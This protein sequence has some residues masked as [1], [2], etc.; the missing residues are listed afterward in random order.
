MG[1]E[2]S[3][4]III[5]RLE[6]VKS[7]KG[8]ASGSTS[9]AWIRY[10]YSLD[11]ILDCYLLPILR[12]E[13]LARRYPVGVCVGAELGAGNRKGVKGLHVDGDHP[14][15][16]N[17]AADLHGLLGVHYDRRTLE[18][19]PA[20]MSDNNIR[21]ESC[22]RLPYAVAEDSVTRPIERR[23]AT[24]LEHE[25]AHLTQ[26]LEDA[27]CAVHPGHTRDVY[28]APRD[29]IPDGEEFRDPFFLECSLVS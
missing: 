2:L 26:E 11:C 10:R 24:R 23:L 22:S 3:V 17:E 20:A 18:R 1:G 21:L 6:D 8:H 14:P 7:A 25:A 28:S 29:S 16:G 5:A 19:R 13:E 9:S 15:T 4:K 12:N 27:A